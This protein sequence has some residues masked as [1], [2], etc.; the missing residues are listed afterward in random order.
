[1]LKKYHLIIISFFSVLTVLMDIGYTLYLPVIFF[2]ILKDYKYIYYIIPSSFLGLV[3]FSG[4]SYLISYGILMIL[5]L[6]LMWIMTKMTKGY[7]MYISIGLLNIISYLIVFGDFP[8]P[9]RFIILL[10][11]SIFVYIYF[12]K[13]IIDA[14]NLKTAFYNHT[15]SEIILMIISIL[16]ALQ[17]QIG[18]LNIGFCLT[19]LFTINATNTWKNIYA[20]IYALLIVLIEVWF[21]KI[22]EALFIPLIV[23]LYCLPAIYPVIIL[24]VF[25]LAVICLNTSYQDEVILSIMIISL[26]C[27]VIDKI[28]YQEGLVKE[29]VRENIYTQVASNV[30]KEV[31]GFAEVLD[32][33]VE[34]IKIPNEYNANISEAIKTIVQKHCD[35]CPQKKNCFSQY[36]GE[37]YYFFRSMLLQKDLY[38]VSLRSFLNSCCKSKELYETTRNLSYR[39]D[40]K[41]KGPNNNALIAQVSGVA[42]ALREYAVE[43]VSKEEVSYELLI[44]LK[45]KIESYG[46]SIVS[47]EIKRSF[48]NDY[49][50][51]VGI[52][53]LNQVECLREI[54]HITDELFKTSST[55]VLTKQ[56]EDI[57]F[58]QIMP[59]LQIDILYGS[60][61]ISSDGEHICGDNYLIKTCENGKF[62]SAISDGMGKGY[63]AFYESDMTLNLV[64]DIIE[65]NLNS[66][67]SLEILNTFYVIQDYLERYATLDLL[68]INRYTKMARFYKMGGTTTYIIKNNG[69][70]EKVVNQNLPFGIDEN[71]EEYDCMLDDGDLILMSSDG[72]FENI[73]DEQ[74]LERF[75]FKIKKDNPQK[76]VYELINYTN[77]Q[78]LKTKDDMTLIA[79]KIK[80]VTPNG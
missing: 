20:F 55:V 53:T 19:I 58:F 1:M 15:Y 23:A 71:I 74:D 32:K 79:L 41:A 57:A 75:L 40:F 52:K 70:I 73:I 34:G 46:Y 78:K 25:L 10:V 69:K 67:T 30:S 72:I 42:L 21:F 60:G 62:V 12:E 22:E 66:Q 47:Y 65:L 28:F 5:V 51:V 48:I 9:W 59:E 35:K 36:K 76:I 45:E 18:I 77:K 80:T 16:G 3:I 29:D 33:F 8:Y 24:N 37:I 13:N 44:K 27:E 31:L 26:I 56:E 68:E 14:F 7:Y 11:L 49:L 43:M 6:I 4:T 63:S 61:S 39:I 54:K 38:D 50:I 17:V 64:K 2:Y